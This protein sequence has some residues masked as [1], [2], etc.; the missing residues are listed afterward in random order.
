MANF[1]SDP[2]DAFI[3]CLR[4]SLRHNPWLTRQLSG[5]V[6]KAGFEIV[7]SRSY[8]YTETAEPIYMLTI[9]DRGAD[10]LVA[11]KN[12]GPELRAALKAEARR[13]LDAGELF[14]FLGFVSLIAM[15][16]M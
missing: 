9:A 7:S 10:T 13:R 1:D 16:S 15:K 5:F 12:I 11:S 2:L 3:Q 4:H 14:G 6:R 8:G